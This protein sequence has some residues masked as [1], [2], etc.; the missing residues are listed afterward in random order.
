MISSRRLLFKTRKPRYFY[1][2]SNV[3]ELTVP[4]AF[5]LLL[6]GAK[7]W[8]QYGVWFC[9]S[10]RLCLFKESDES[11]L[12]LV[13]KGIHFHREQ[14][15]DF[16]PPLVF[17]SARPRYFCEL[18]NEFKPLLVS[19]SGSLIVSKVNI[20]RAVFQGSRPCCLLE[21]SKEFKQPLV[22]RKRSFTLLEKQW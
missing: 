18:S 16:E 9:Q 19:E 12:L 2:L 1:V 4:E 22:L 8:I 10:V 21:Q 20:S 17:K 6:F 7:K 3:F 11:T 13:S 15:N 14:S 5:E